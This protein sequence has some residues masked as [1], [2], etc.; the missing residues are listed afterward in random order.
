M[1]I[2]HPSSPPVRLGQEAVLAALALPGLLALS[3]M[4]MVIN[5]DNSINYYLSRDMLSGDFFLSGWVLS[6]TSFFFTDRL[7]LALCTLAGLSPLW[8]LYVGGALQAWVLGLSLRFLLGRRVSAGIFWSVYACWAAASHLSLFVV[9]VHI[10][11]FI[12]GLWAAI[13]Y[14]GGGRG[15]WGCMV[16]LLAMAIA[17]DM[18]AVTAVLLPLGLETLWYWW[19]SLDTGKGALLR[20]SMICLALAASGG[21][22]LARLVKALGANAPGLPEGALFSAPPW[23]FLPA[24]LDSFQGALGLF[25]YS[26]GTGDGLAHLGA[27]V[28][29]ACL[30]LAL[31]WGMRE[32]IAPENRIIRFLALSALLVPPAVLV[33]GLPVNYY[34]G[35]YLLAPCGAAAALLACLCQEIKGWQ[36]SGRGTCLLAAAL[37]VLLAAFSCWRGA[38][39]EPSYAERRA[40]MQQV[41]ACLSRRN[42]P[43]WGYGEYWDAS[44]NEIF[45][46]QGTRVLP[47][48]PA[49]GAG[50]MPMHWFSRPADYSRPASFVILRQVRLPGDSRRLP[51]EDGLIAFGSDD[52]WVISEAQARSVF[53][54]PVD[55]V[56]TDHYRVFIYD[57]DISSGLSR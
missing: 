44:G 18:Y 41:D 45:S 54:E 20:R 49:Q 43:A 21:L 13:C 52:A 57:H 5:S 27:A 2:F 50:L 3:R 35:R 36:G 22:A 28:L 39:M 32:A 31:C 46:S 1:R 37:M 29:A 14:Y 8:L 7:P 16:L 53:G 4:G 23:K 15:R 55:I 56:Q 26:L 48:L 11:T 9:P 24:W 33:L 51:I 19:R 47:L 30:L 38:I 40:L 6:T 10:A 17:S 34:T 42:L 25:P 12:L